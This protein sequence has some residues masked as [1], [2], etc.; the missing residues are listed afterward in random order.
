MANEN[1]LNDKD[2]EQVSG[3]V[4][5]PIAY[6]DDGINPGQEK[7]RTKYVVMDQNGNVVKEFLSLQEATRYAI[8]NGLFN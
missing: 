6:F 4:I 1:V 2:L 8:D 5:V 3:G 7:P